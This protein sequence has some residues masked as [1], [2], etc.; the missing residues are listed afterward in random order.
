MR[1][2]LFIGVVFDPEKPV[3][4][5]GDPLFTAG[6]QE[7]YTVIPGGGVIG[8]HEVERRVFFIHGGSVGDENRQTAFTEH[9]GQR[10][11]FPESASRD[12]DT[13]EI[14]LFQGAAEC[15]GS[16]IGNEL[17]VERFSEQLQ[18]TAPLFK[19]GENVVADVPQRVE[20]I[21]YD[22]DLSRRT[23]WAAARD[24]GPFAVDRGDKA[25][26]GKIFQS[27]PQSDVGNPEHLGKLRPPGQL[28][29][30]GKFAALYERGD[31]FG[32][33]RSF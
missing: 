24:K 16:D 4:Q 32:G 7:S 30:Q 12:Q 22:Q 26:F 3:A 17:S 33:D 15:F 1:Q 29:T 8:P 11:I 23:A 31:L 10:I 2:E 21:S 27:A 19:S 18:F 25:C 20:M 9:K 5:K 6:A 13:G 28:G 14:I